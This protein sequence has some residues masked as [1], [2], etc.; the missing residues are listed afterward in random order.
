MIFGLPS[1]VGVAPLLLCIVLSL[2]DKSLIIGLK[3]GKG[4]ALN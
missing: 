1:I 2:F 4:G 3:T